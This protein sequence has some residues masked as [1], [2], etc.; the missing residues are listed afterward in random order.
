MKNWAKDFKKRQVWTCIGLALLASQAVGI[1]SAQAETVKKHPRVAQLEDSLRESASLY[2]KSRLP[3]SPFLVNVSVDPLRRNSSGSSRDQQEKLPLLDP[4]YDDMQ[5][6]WDDPQVTLQELINRANRITVSIALS[7]I[8]TDAE[9]IEVKEALTQSLHLTAA[10]DEIKIEIRKWSSTSN[11]LFYIVLAVTVIFVMLTGFFAVQRSMVGKLASALASQK[12]AAQAGG[13]SSVV[14]APVSSSS[15]VGRGDGGAATIRGDVNL[16]DPIRAR[17]LITGFV[18]QLQARPHFPTLTAMMEL[19]A[20]GAKDS[21]GLGAVI[22]ELPEA[23]K[24]RLF[25]LGSSKDWFT[26][27]NT[28]GML[29]LREL[30]LVQRLV[31]EPVSSRSKVV[32]EM[33]I[34]VWRLGDEMPVFLRSCPRDQALAILA[35]LPRGMAV[36]VARRAFPGAWAEILDP[37]FAPK[38][39]KD[40]D[41]QKIADQA[42]AMKPLSNLADFHRLKQENELREYLKTSSVEEEREIYL[43]YK[44]EGALQAMRPPFYVVLEASE[45]ELMELVP[46]VK[47]EQWALALFNVDRPIRAKIQAQMTDK[48]KMLLG[49]RLKTLDSVG[50]SPFEVGEARESLGRLFK[51]L[52]TQAGQKQPTLK[53]A[54]VAVEQKA[55]DETLK[56]A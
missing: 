37:S 16:S 42:E 55:E 1:P 48:Q 40:A 13:G 4:T 28:P 52:K 44:P 9:L 41:A 32:E 45:Q 35:S 46:R 31:R 53:E 3:E 10:R 6:E 47:V 12:P 34:R 50:V 8:L 49:E 27:L 21:A 43:A 18:A 51:Q 30:E 23:L 17:E 19:E 24:A 38:P 7:T 15:P 54:G 22:A 33:L 29:T 39:L 56:A 20:Y 5:D 26:A 11:R 2:L 25:A 36:S 14:A